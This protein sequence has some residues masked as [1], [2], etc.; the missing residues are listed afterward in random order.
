M[1]NVAEQTFH[2]FCFFLLL[3][4]QKLV[5]VFFKLT[6]ANFLVYCHSLW[7]NDIIVIWMNFPRICRFSK[8]TFFSTTTTFFVFATWGRH[9]HLVCIIGANFIFLVRFSALFLDISSS[10]LNPS[11]NFFGIKSYFK[12][13]R[14][15]IWRTYL[16]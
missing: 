4:D 3:I 15:E 6:F 14:S 9:Q 10:R 16:K 13:Q 11:E 1:S 12:S 8:E 7:S 5:E 2:K